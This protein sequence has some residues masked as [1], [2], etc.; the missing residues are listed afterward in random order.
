MSAKKG[1]IVFNIFY[2]IFSVLLTIFAV[3]F[4]MFGYTLYHLDI[5]ANTVALGLI[6]TMFYSTTSVVLITSLISNCAGGCDNNIHCS[7]SPFEYFN[8]SY[9]IQLFT[10][11]YYIS[12][13]IITT[14]A[15]SLFI[16]N[17]ILQRPIAFTPTIET[18]GIMLGII[19]GTA[20]IV[21]IPLI[22]YYCLCKK[23]NDI[24]F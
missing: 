10:V 9:I 22:I 23:H 7:V 13:L 21:S 17:P 18:F 14:Q 6:C 20:L 8:R 12:F 15:L 16:A 1:E 5:R 11:Y 19:C 2:C 24:D 3:P 4:V